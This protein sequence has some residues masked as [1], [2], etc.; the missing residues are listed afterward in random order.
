[1]KVTIKEP[2]PKLYHPNS[3]VNLTNEMVKAA[4]REGEVVMEHTVCDKGPWY[5]VAIPKGGAWTFHGDDLIFHDRL[6]LDTVLT[7]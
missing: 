2:N 4:G 6:S 3:E 1:M 7:L 5:T